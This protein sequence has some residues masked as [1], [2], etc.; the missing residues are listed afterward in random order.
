[1]KS[2]T[3]DTLKKGNTQRN[4][5]TGS[6]LINRSADIQKRG[7]Y[8]KNEHQKKAADLPKRTAVERHRNVKT[9]IWA[10]QS[11]RASDTT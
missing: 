9:D 7:M 3:V 5:Q 8:L 6:L 11:P 10:F 1:M 4:R 2:Q